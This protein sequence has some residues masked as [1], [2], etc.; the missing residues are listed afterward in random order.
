MITIERWARGAVL[1]LAATLAFA[2]AGCQQATDSESED[3]ESVAAAG[4]ELDP[5][6]GHDDH[7][8]GGVVLPGS[9][10][11]AGDENKDPQPQPWHNA[12]NNSSR[13]PG[14]DPVD[15]STHTSVVAPH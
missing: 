10:C 14:P 1:A 15:P 5:S 4:Q 2:S 11:E 9:D 12:G 3:D 8:Q 6:D 13:K 7:S